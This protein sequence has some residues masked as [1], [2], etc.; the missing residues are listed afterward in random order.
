MQQQQLFCFLSMQNLRIM[1]RQF[2]KNVGSDSRRCLFRFLW[3]AKAGLCHSS[4]INGLLIRLVGFLKQNCFF[5]IEV[6][7]SRSSP[8]YIILKRSRNRVYLMFTFVSA[9]YKKICELLQ[10]LYLY[11][12]SNFCFF[13]YTPFLKEGNLLSSV[14]LTVI[15][16]TLIPVHLLNLYSTNHQI[17]SVQFFTQFNY[18]YCYLFLLSIIFGIFAIDYAFLIFAV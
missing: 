8:L 15:N 4:K 5:T 9:Q 7:I 12:I 3:L 10:K 17:N 16:V 18:F 14:T 6:A 2:F 11:N 1:A 13:V